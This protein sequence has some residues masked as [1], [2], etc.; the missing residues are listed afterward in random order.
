MRRNRPFKVL[1]IVLMVVAASAV[2]GLVI[3]HL[4]NWLVPAILGLHSITFWQAIGLFVL[5]KILFG[6]FHRHGPRGRWGRHMNERWAQMSP[7]DREKFRSGMRG[8]RGCRPDREGMP[9]SG[10]TSV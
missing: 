6:G 3:Q 5:S 10:Q 1:K 8:W 2:F 4:W 7:E 9:A